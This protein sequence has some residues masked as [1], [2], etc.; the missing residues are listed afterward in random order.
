MN[1]RLF[2]YWDWLRS[3]FWF[4]PAL[5][6][7]TAILL[8]LATVAL[9]AGAA[10]QWLS[11]H[12]LIYSGGAEGASAVL[13]AIAGSMITIAGVVFS[14]TLVALSLASS[15]FGPRLLRNFM[16]DTTTQLVLGTFVATFLYCLFVLRTIRRESAEVSEFV[17]HL[18][19]TLGIL[20]VVISL[21]VLI[22]FI[23]HVSSSIQADELIASVYRDLDDAIN[24]LFPEKIGHAARDD[25]GDDDALAAFEREAGAVESARDGYLQ[26]ID[27][28]GLLKLA[29]EED[30]LLRIPHRPGHYI[31]AGTP[32]LLVRPGS[33]SD[34]EFS[35]RVNGLFIIGSQ[36]TGV[37][38]LEYPVNQLAE[39][40]V[41]ALSPGVNDPFTALSC[42]DRL[43]SALC[44]LAQRDM[45]AA[46]RYDEA[47][48]L[49]VI[50]APLSFPAIVEAAFD[51]IRQ[52]GR[53]SAAVT[54]RLLETI[55]VIATQT[56]RA[57]DRTAL[58]SQAEMI[59]RGSRDGLAEETDR[60]TVQRRYQAAVRRLD[61]TA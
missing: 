61:G 6:A 45:P 19:V 53:S 15:Q 18:S 22:Y 2:H 20:A 3:T 47:D 23:H 46:G 17:P 30:L 8:A 1:L 40:A 9:D 5:M 39:I 27:G 28:E 48:T 21:G 25:D 44:R 4:L 26:A 31:V 32:L 58:R 38:D 50:T 55:A 12:G 37:Q 7:G 59:V 13:G 57:G 24:R 36:R 54:V 41:R 33:R 16:R 60:N 35:E 14:L 43:G 11:A 56:R 29:T 42:I 34:D 51:P 52:Y 49:R 10:G